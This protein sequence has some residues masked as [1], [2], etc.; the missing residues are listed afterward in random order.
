MLEVL[1]TRFGPVTPTI[2]AGLEHVKES[3]KLTRLTRQAVICASLQA[4][5]D[6]LYKELPPPQPAS[7]RGK[8][9]SRK[10]PE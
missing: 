10:P 9:R 4:Y 8:R 3:E 7:T 5:Q 6:T 2:T 1:E